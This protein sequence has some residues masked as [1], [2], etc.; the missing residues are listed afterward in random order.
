MDQP[1]QMYKKSLEEVVHGLELDLAPDADLFMMHTRILCE[2]LDWYKAIGQCPK[3][4]FQQ[5]VAWAVF[6]H[7]N[8]NERIQNYMVFKL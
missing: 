8:V 5:H 7:P 3:L 4:N 1:N 6:T 2:C